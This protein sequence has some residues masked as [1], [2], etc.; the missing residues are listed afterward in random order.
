MKWRNKLR[1]S[2]LRQYDLEAARRSAAGCRTKDLSHPAFIISTAHGAIYRQ[3][4][5][6]PDDESQ[7]VFLIVLTI[8]VLS[9]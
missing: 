4:D 2:C 5:G 6:G 7:F 9:L 8:I 3:D 1:C